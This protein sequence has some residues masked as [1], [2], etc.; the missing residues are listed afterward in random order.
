M[1]IATNN[2]AAHNGQSMAASGGRSR[3]AWLF[4]GLALATLVGM[5]RAQTPTTPNPA[6]QTQAT[7]ATASD[8]S[9]A[10]SKRRQRQAEDA[11]LAGAKKLQ[12]NDPFGA[13]QE[14]TRAL[15]LN[16]A[17]RDC[18]LAILLA[19]QH[20]V[21]DLVQQAAKARAAGEAAK[22]QS[23][24]TQ[25]RVIDPTNPIVLEHEV[26]SLTGDSSKKDANAAV[27]LVADQVQSRTAD[28]MVA[29][30]KISA[31]L[32]AGL[33]HLQ[34]NPG[35]KSF[36]LRGTSEE[37]LRNVAQAYGIRAVM[38]DSVTRKGFA[39]DMVEVDY[40]Q[41][42]STLMMM[43]N[44]FAVPVDESTVL[45][46]RDD[47]ADRNRLQHMLEETI[48]LEGATPDEM[49]DVAGVV[50][51]LF[52]VRVVSPGVNQTS[53]TLRAP[54]DLLVPLNRTLEDLM[55]RT[56]EVM[57]EVKLYEVSTTGHT[58]A[59]AS[60]PTAFGIYN[61]D[62]AAAQLV[63]A[64]SSLVQQA[65]AQ[66]LISST[67]SNL[68]IAGEL[69]ASGLVSSSL[70]SS[71]IGVIGGG[72]MMTGI[73]ETGTVGF[74]LGLN[75]TDTRTL[76]DIH[77]MVGDRED[78]I[79]REGSKYPIMTSSISTGISGT[80][81]SNAT[82]NGVSVASLLAQ[83]TGGA[84]TIPQVTYEDLGLTLDATPTIEKS[85]RVH[86]KLELKIESLSGSTNEG[87]PILESRQIKSDIT[88]GAGQSALLVSDVNHTETAAI[89]GIPGL[90]ELPGFQLP[91]TST[92]EKDTGQ[93]VVLV[94][95]RVVQRRSDLVSGPRLKVR[96]QQ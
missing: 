45:F 87:N 34:P 12:Q 9:P 79:F 73:T 78:A 25:A 69:I 15:K 22:A 31:P 3:F 67:D 68:F 36:H 85:G 7:G 89:T 84:S 58:S 82:I 2:S 55:D 83:Y 88:V 30:W 53:L 11:Y 66:G 56:G 86:L 48:Y 72:T 47:E 76:D 13:E 49:K 81:A 61:V 96:I 27:K 42:I 17:N 71:T 23:L 95:P 40:D 94:T 93:L 39:F 6:R 50:Q 20:Q 92:G 32:L 59:G 19:R 8:S 14:F 10:I 64:N 29:P 62:A 54:E 33:I 35:Q 41:A 60:L 26:E 5:G 44:V 37:M 57:I 18:A 77:M 4:C 52:N 16:P 38:D 46:V 91:E 51:N 1:A 21:T 43:A 75:S 74:N 65:I 70:L 28:P 90:S 24:L 80:P 63:S